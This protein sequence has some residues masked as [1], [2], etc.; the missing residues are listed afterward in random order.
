MRLVKRLGWILILVRR[1]LNID[2]SILTESGLNVI[3]ILLVTS[4][5]PLNQIHP[6][7]DNRQDDLLVLCI[8]PN[9]S[10]RKTLPDRTNPD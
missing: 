9:P 1:L 4:H 7:P 2:S 5:F 6:Y 10:L 8:P 3:I